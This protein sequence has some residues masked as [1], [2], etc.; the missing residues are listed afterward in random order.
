V[1]EVFPEGGVTIRYE[2]PLPSEAEDAEQAH[3]LRKLVEDTLEL[4]STQEA[5]LSAGKGK[6]ENF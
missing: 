3:I 1:G 5:A 4:P 6:H 2:V